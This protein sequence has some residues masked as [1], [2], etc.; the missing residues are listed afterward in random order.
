MPFLIIVYGSCKFG[1][2]QLFSAQIPWAVARIGKACE[3][4]SLMGHGNKLMNHLL[5][6]KE[7]GS[8]NT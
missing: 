2:L 4:V 3:D 1:G 7:K 5:K 6:I 8:W